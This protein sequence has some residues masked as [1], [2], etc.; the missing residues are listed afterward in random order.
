MPWVLSE[1]ADKRSN[2]SRKRRGSPDISLV[3]RDREF[4][5]ILDHIARTKS[6]HIC[7][8]ESVGKSALLDRVFDFLKDRTAPIPFFA[9]GAAGH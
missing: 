6:L 1:S 7:G 2:R 9:V 4:T 3:A 8:D 5:V